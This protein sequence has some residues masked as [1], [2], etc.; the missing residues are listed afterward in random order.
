MFRN[1]DYYIMLDIKKNIY[2]YYYTYITTKVDC[3]EFSNNNS[4][5][6]NC[7][8]VLSRRVWSSLSV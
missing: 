6:R 5:S 1:K 8:C 7:R 4:R 3:L 2:I